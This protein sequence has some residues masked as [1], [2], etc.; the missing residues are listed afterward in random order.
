MKFIVTPTSTGVVG[1]KRV[2]IFQPRS[3]RFEPTFLQ[4]RWYD[5]WVGK[6][7]RRRR[8]EAKE[9]EWKVKIKTVFGK[10][11]WRENFL[12]SLAPLP[13]LTLGWGIFLFPQVFVAIALTCFH[14]RRKLHSRYF[15]SSKWVTDCSHTLSSRISIKQTANAANKINKMIA[16]LIRRRENLENII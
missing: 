8:E 4:C 11:F 10:S 1:S 14:G 3:V 12:R 13:V 15:W 7:K 2:L 5:E 9:R 6:Q 16:S